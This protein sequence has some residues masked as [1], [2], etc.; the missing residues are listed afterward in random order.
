M[1][2]SRAN[3]A[4]GAIRIHHGIGG[5]GVH[6]A[7]VAGPERGRVWMIAP[8]ARAQAGVAGTRAG[9]CGQDL[10]ITQR[11]L[12]RQHTVRPS[13]TRDWPRSPC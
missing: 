2:D 5:F 8:S 4:E 13:R 7:I 12:A 10:A 6:A 3:A 1:D 11:C 9:T